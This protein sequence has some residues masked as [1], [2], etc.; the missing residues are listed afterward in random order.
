RGRISV[1]GIAVSAAAGCGELDAVAGLEGD[2]GEL[3]RRDLPVEL[4]HRLPLG[5]AILL[6]ERAAVAA[7]LAAE[8]GP[9]LYLVPIAAL[10]AGDR[11]FRGQERAAIAEAAAPLPGAARIRD[12]LAVL[13]PQREARLEHFRRI[14]AAVAVD[15]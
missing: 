8:D 3:A 9:G 11:H 1:G 6:D 12:Q 10:A 5:R 13:D 15:G 14:E 4:L 2:V 7:G